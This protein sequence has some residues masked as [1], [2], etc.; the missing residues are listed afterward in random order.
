VNLFNYLLRPPLSFKHQNLVVGQ[1]GIFI[2][3][4][5]ANTLDAGST[6][7]KTSGLQGRKYTLKMLSKYFLVCN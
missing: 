4:S 3:I 5:D 1:M 6:K 7:L 2:A